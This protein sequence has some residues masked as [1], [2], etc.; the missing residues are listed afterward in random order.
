MDETSLEE[1]FMIGRE[2]FTEDDNSISSD[3]DT[4]MLYREV[5]TREAVPITGKIG[6]KKEKCPTAVKTPNIQCMVPFQRC[7]IMSE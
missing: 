3:G 4:N 7:Q 1:D 2:L 5:N 6:G